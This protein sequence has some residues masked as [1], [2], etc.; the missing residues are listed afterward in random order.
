[1]LAAPTVNLLKFEYYTEI[2]DAVQAR[3]ETS[4][5]SAPGG[6]ATCKTVLKELH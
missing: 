2:Q 6:Q 3:T 4:D 1:M 5:Q